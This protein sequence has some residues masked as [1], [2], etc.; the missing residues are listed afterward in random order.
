MKTTTLTLA[1]LLAA[2]SAVAYAVPITSGHADLD[3]DYSAG[4][5]TLNWKTY[6]PMSA[7]TPTNNDNYTPAG[8]PVSVPLAN[9]YV[10]PAGA[11]WSCLGAAGTT[12]YRLKQ[13]NDPL[14]VWLGY[15]TEGVAL[16]AFAG[17]K[18]QLQLVS[19][20]SAPVGGRFVLYS[21]NFAG[22]PTYLLNSTSGGCNRPSFPGGGITANVHAHAW[23]AFSTPGVYVLRFRARGTLTGGGVVNSANVDFT[24]NVP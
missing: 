16:G 13:A 18:V 7:G 17:N 3:I 19:V 11:Q 24:F 2:P 21:T 14:Q 12:V 23:W 22:T 15:N 1:L 4:A 20:V 8:N 10:V 9:S 5:L 6:T